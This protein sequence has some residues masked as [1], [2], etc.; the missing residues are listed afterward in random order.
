MSDFSTVIL[1][2]AITSL[3]LFV[4]STVN[5]RQLRAQLI[6][7]KL[8][9]MKRRV[10]E[11][12]ELSATLEPL[13]ENNEFSKLINDEVI[14]ITQVMVKLSPKDTLLNV[15]LEEAEKRS[16]DLLDPNAKAELFRLMESD[17]AVARAEYA[18][19][20][21]ARVIRKRQSADK[22]PEGKMEQLIVGLNWS[23]FMVKVVTNV[24]Q[25][26]QAANNGNTLR[27][28]AYYRKAMELISQSHQ[29]D[30]RMSQLTKEM[31]EILSG[32]RTA[33]S[34][35]LMPESLYN[36]QHKT[37]NNEVDDNSL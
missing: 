25:G 34:L 36:P 28:S 20:E 15:S 24:G 6:S 8:T 19:T 30:E 5:K 2:I 17:A 18:I 37:V 7:Q 12:E 9:Q 1:L 22:I 21:A 3:S 4:V 27:A 10:T 26:H 35:E 16:Q 13:V 29:R 33:L 14:D 32:K 31:G 11:L 23:N